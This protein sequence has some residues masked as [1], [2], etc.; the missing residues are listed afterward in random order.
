MAEVNGRDH[1]VTRCPPVGDVGRGTGPAAR[2]PERPYTSGVRRD[3]HGSVGRRR[4]ATAGSPTRSPTP[5][6]MRRCGCVSMATRSLLCNCGPGGARSKLPAI[7][8][9]HRATHRST[10]PTTRHAPTGP[11]AHRSRRNAAEETFLALGDGARLWLIEAASAGTAR[12]KVKMGEAVELA[13]LHGV[14][15]VD[16]ALGHAAGSAGSP[17]VTWHEPRGEPARTTTFR[18]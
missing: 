12:I 13:A 2:L 8:V 16:W 14:G 1:Q 17:M 7:A 18:R 6:L 9:R 3:P 4:S 5:W 11:A 15:R 10:T